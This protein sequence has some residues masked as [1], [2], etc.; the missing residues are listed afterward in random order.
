VAKATDRE[1][2]PSKVRA[3]SDVPFTRDF[4][5]HRENIC[6]MCSGVSVCDVL[7]PYKK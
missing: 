2:L 1:A 4:S 5:K 3:L 7:I 6:D